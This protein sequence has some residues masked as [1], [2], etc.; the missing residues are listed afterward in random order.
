MHQIWHCRFGA[1]LGLAYE[2]ICNVEDLLVRLKVFPKKYFDYQVLKKVLK[3]GLV[4]V[5]NCKKH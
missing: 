3:R 4:S 2:I 5:Q 1:H